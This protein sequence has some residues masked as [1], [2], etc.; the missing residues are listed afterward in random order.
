MISCLPLATCDNIY[1]W[2]CAA[3]HRHR[4]FRCNLPQREL[5]QDFCYNPSREVVIHS[6]L[7]FL[8]ELIAHFFCKA[9]HVFDVE[10]F[11]IIENSLAADAPEY[12]MLIGGDD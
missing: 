3:K 6:N 2:A 8:S 5:A 4:V 1:F 7:L 11:A 9:E 10:Y 12:L